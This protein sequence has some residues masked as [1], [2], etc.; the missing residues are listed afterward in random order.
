MIDDLIHN[1]VSPSSWLFE[2]ERKVIT[3]ALLIIK[4]GLVDQ[5]NRLAYINANT[6]C[7]SELINLKS[8]ISY[9]LLLKERELTRHEADVVEN[10]EYEHL[11]K[12][13]RNLCMFNSSKYN[14]MKA[15]IERLSVLVKYVDELNWI[16]KTAVNKV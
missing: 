7:Q 13:D 8:R 12:N 1:S 4:G 16:L 3:Q 2:E 11:T 6:Q 9:V 10:G 15:V 14:D 5:D